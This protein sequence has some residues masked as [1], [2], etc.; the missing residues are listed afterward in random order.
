MLRV[1]IAGKEIKRIEAEGNAVE[2]AAEIGCMVHAVYNVTRQSDPD[3]A[4]R[5]RTAVIMAML[6]MS[7][8][9]EEKDMM[10]GAQRA[11]CTVV[12]IPKKKED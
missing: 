6:P 2:I 5:L 7:P 9:W 4:E 12:K 1:D 3:T 11:E 8:V 10:A